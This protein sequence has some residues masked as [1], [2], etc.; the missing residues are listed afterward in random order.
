MVGNP[1]Y[2]RLGL[3]MLPVKALDTL[4]PIYGLTAFALLLFYLATARFSL[5]APVGGI[6]FAKIF[7]DF[8]FHLWSIDLYRRWV[9]PGAAA[10]PSRALLASLVE[11]FTFQILRH[12]GALLGWISFITGTKRWGRA[13][14]GARRQI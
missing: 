8:S 6:I 1:R 10:R 12:T 7:V 9:D 13:D 5:I 14:E 11:P 3:L 4:Q 2:G